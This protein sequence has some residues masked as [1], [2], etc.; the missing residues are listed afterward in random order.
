MQTPSAPV[1]VSIVD[2]QLS[3]GTI[4]NLMIV[5]FLAQLVFSAM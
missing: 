3:V 5:V 4:L 2:I 1:R